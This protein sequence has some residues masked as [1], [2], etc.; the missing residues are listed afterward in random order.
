MDA[1]D[2]IRP[3]KKLLRHG[4]RPHMDASDPIRPSKKLLRHGGRPHMDASDPIRPS[5]KLLRHGGRPHMGP[6]I[7]RDDPLKRYAYENSICDSPA[8]SGERAD[9]VRST[10]LDSIFKQPRRFRCKTVIASAAIAVG[11]LIAERPPHRT[12]RA[13][14]PHTAPTLGA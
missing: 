7:R 8:A 13:A 14:F 2:P 6:C 10:A 3:S 5:K 9:R 11:T 12:V 1:S 4:G